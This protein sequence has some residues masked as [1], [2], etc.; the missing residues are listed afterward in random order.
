MISFWNYSSND[1]WPLYLLVDKKS[2][3]YKISPILSSKTLWDF[4]KKEECDSIVKKWQMYFQA[5]N[6]KGRNFLNLNKNNNN[7]IY[8]TY[9]KDGVWLKNFSY[10]NLLYIHITRLITNHTPTGKYR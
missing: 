9:S 8:S 7:S 5:S 2:K 1:K 6:Y 4:S 3:L 10:S